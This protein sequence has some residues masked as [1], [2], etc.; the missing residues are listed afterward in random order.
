METQTVDAPP[1]PKKKSPGLM[2]LPKR[3]DTFNAWLTARGAEVLLP[4][5]QWEVTRWRA[6]GQTHVVYV[7]KRGYLNM[8]DDVKKAVFAFLGHQSWFAGVATKRKPTKDVEIRALLKRDGDECF[9][10]G[11]AMGED[12]TVEHLVSLAHGGPNHIA[13]KALAHERCNGL[14]GH[15]SLME[16]I[17]LRETMHAKTQ[18]AIQ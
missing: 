7:N 9:L 18:G 16:K 13:N 11:L 6:N 10:C 15:L 4:T 8:S 17:R 14:M 3:V 12:C 5:S 2:G 1:V